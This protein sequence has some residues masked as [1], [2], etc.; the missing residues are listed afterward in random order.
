ME[1]AE[2]EAEAREYQ[3]ARDEMNERTSRL[4]RERN[5][6]NQKASE[7]FQRIRSMKNRDHEISNELTRL[8]LEKEANFEELARIRE[9]L[10]PLHEE[11]EKM[12]GDPSISIP[13][14]SLRRE[15]RDLEWKLQTTVMKMEEERNYVERIAKIQRKLKPAEERENL[16]S[17][18]RKKQKNA[19]A[20]R[21]RIAFIKAR[22]PELVTESRA[23]REK[24]TEPIEKATEIRKAADEK[25]TEFLKAKEQADLMHQKFID[26]LKLVKSCREQLS[27]VKG[28]LKKKRSAATR[29]LID[30]TAES[31]FEKWKTGEKLTIDEFK[32][33]VHKGL[34]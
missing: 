34:L 33:L 20:L 18:I 21:A 31:A 11:F 10:I 30:Q 4:A 14:H 19:R 32:L 17:E 3:R 16:R 24:L 15:Q 27:G 13:Y 8:R 6:L 25:H 2:I 29:K 1:L 26:K 5:E 23:I 28:A 22:I 7:F 12:K 9:E